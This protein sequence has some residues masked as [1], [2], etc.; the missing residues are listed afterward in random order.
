MG[1]PQDS[2]LRLNEK[3]QYGDDVYIPGGYKQG[4]AV[5]SIMEDDDFR[6]GMEGEVDGCTWP[7]EADHLRVKYK[8]MESGEE[9]FP[10]FINVH[11]KD[12]QPTE[13]LCTPQ[14][15]NLRLNEK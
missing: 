7:Y 1:T 13:P 12:I 5:I 14:D 15:S 4:D 11:I 9:E 2:N 10:Q 3:Y 6:H 8:S